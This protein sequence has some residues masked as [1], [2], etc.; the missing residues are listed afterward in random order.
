[1]KPTYVLEVVIIR[2]ITD[3]EEWKANC[4]KHEHIGYMRAKFKTKKDV[5]SYYDRHNPHLRSLNAHGTWISDWDPNTSLLYI[6][7]EDHD[8]MDT[9][10]AFDS[11]DE[12]TYSSFDTG[13]GKVKCRVVIKLDIFSRCCLNE[14]S[15]IFQKLLMSISS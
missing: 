13:C 15:E 8:M 4:S 7:R 3:S 11:E 6:V 14:M 10:P 2:F 5:A 12:P 1:M 9:S